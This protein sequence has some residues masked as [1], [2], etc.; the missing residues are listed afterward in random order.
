M[1]FN[2][3]LIKGTATL[4]KRTGYNAYGEPEF[5]AGEE[6]LCR[7]REV[8]EVLLDASGSQ[9]VSKAILHPAQPLEVGD[10]IAQGGGSID[11]AHEIRFSTVTESL[12]GEKYYRAAV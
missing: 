4:Y 10:F 12:G 8:A 3:H 5:A 7:W 1:S 11:A 2:G 9:F 6:I